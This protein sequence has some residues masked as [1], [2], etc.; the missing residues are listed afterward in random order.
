MHLTKKEELKKE[1]LSKSEKELLVEQLVF[2]SE[3]YKTL[4]SIKHMIVAWWLL[5]GIGVLLFI[6]FFILIE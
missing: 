4:K 2:Q 5:I 1:E 6:Y 3:N